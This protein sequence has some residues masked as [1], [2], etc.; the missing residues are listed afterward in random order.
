[1]GIKGMWQVNATALTVLIMANLA[2]AV[3]GEAIWIGV[4]A[5]SLLIAMFLCFKQGLRLGHGACGVSSTIEG[6]RR[7]GEQVAAQLDRNYLSQAW[8]RG[9][10]VRGLLVSALIPYAAGGIYI[11]L[12]LLRQGAPALETPVIAARLAAW[13]LSL[14]YWTLIMHWH[15]DFVTLTPAI[16]VM[17]LVSPFALPACTFVGYLQGPRL[18]ARTEA[19]MKAGRRRAKAKARVGK[20]MAPRQQKPEI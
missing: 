1:M 9:T 6:A 19:A 14:P 18:W 13:L 15:A 11:V 3:A 12:T 5:A 16:A 20:A 17:L 2:L 4:G 8:S 7:A 10:G